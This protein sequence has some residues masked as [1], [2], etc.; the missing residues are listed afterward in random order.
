MVTR[1]TIRASDL[2]HTS[3]PAIGRLISQMVAT[4]RLKLFESDRARLRPTPEAK[5]LLIYVERM[6]TG[7]T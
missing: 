1:T 4:V 2:M 6:F 3:Q 7:W 5:A